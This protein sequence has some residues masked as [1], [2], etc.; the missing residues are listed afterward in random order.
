MTLLSLYI[1]S[2]VIAIQLKI[3]DGAVTGSFDT[4]VSAGT[5]W[6]VEK[7]DR[8]LIGDDKGGNGGSINGDD[9]NFNYN[10][11]TISR[12]TKVTHELELNYRNLGL[13][14]RG[15]YFYDFYNEHKNK[16]SSDAKDEI[17]KHINLL[18]FYIQYGFD[19]KEHLLNVR[20]GHQVLS[21]GESTFIGNGINIV[22]PLNL[23][24]L[25][26]PGSE[27]RDALLPVPMISAIYDISD[28]IS[29]EGFYQFSFEHTEI[30]P[31]GSFFSASDVVGPGGDIA[32]LGNKEGAAGM[33][34]P[35][36][37]SDAGDSGQ[38]GFALHVFSPALNE[39]EF[40]LFYINYHSR[41]PIL[42]ARTGTKEGDDNG[43]YLGSSHYL[44]EYP[45]DIHLIGV[46]FNTL[47]A[48]SGIALQGEFTYR[49]NMPLQID[50]NE[51][52]PALLTPTNTGT[53]QLG[54]YN[55]SEEIRAYKR[56]KVGQWQATASKLFG[57]SNLF[58]ATSCS[59]IGEVGFMRVFN[60]EDKR[61]LKYDGP[62]I[63]TADAFSWGYRIAAQADYANAIGPVRLS[64]GIA[65]SHDVQGISPTPG[66]SFV[67]GQSAYTIGLKASY[68]ERWQANINYT[69]YSGIE[70]I[71]LLHDRDFVAFNIKYFF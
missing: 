39:T 62:L 51:L 56:K 45:D 15:N 13:F 36:A 7:H 65:Y 1:S 14:V 23:S 2:P 54:R 28:N 31:A 18:D 4:T 25:Q 44:L 12:I 9:G 19:F 32:W 50:D 6:R 63:A 68:I 30:T 52:I 29:V 20:L 55:Y 49:N 37:D 60:M 38:F 24:M 33:G 64:P 46:S 48:R 42:S 71:N 11:G 47:L 34:I 70:H 43:N 66:G 22:N 16:L 5:A 67:E 8:D 40:G 58:K 3:G 69:R 61:R 59:V 21:W 27:I 53:T 35:R 26:K 41:L 57:P 10:R 17:G